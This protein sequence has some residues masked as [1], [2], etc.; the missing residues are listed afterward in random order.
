MNKYYDNNQLIDITLLYIEDD[1][2]RRL[3]YTRLLK[4]VCA[5]VYVSANVE[6]GLTQSAKLA[7]E[8]ILTDI[9]MQD[10]QGV[11]ML[12][13]LREL[14]SDVPVVILSICED[15]ACFQKAIELDVSAY[16][17]HPSSVEELKN[18]F[19]KIMKKCRP[20]NEQEPVVLTDTLVYQENIK[21]LIDK[22]E[23][24]SLNKKEARLLEY[25]LKYQNTLLSYSDIK[26]HIWPGDTE[27]SSAS[28]RTLIKNLRKKGL[29]SLIQ[30]ISGRGYLLNLPADK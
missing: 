2:E 29:S 12:Q 5:K 30:N 26:K 24:V 16:L 3:F 7:P 15:V 25:L 9:R 4:G 8:I 13:R 14:E 11:S 6:D 19:C 18:T 22:G 28:L 17:L 27:V 23:Q 1:S 20:E 21:S 10:R